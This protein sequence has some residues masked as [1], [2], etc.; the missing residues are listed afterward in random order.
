MVVGDGLWLW[1]IVYHPQPP[2]PPTEPGAGNISNIGEEK[3]TSVR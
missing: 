2:S 1:E 3:G